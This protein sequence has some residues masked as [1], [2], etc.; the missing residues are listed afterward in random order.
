MNIKK[1][2]ICG[3]PQPNGIPQGNNLKRL[4]NQLID[5]S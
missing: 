1:V 2:I 4:I 3:K 5:Y